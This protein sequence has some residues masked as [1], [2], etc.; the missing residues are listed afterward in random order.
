MKI[1]NI[2]ILIKYFL[3]IGIFTLFIT[4][5]IKFYLTIPQKFYLKF[6]FSV[7]YAW[8]TLGMNIN[9]IMPLIA[10]IDKQINQFKK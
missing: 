6:I 7:T 3:L 9:L 1:L 5:F 2:Y 10:E 4:F 8:F